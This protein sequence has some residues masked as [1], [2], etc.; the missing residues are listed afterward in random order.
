MT[1]DD[2]DALKEQ[3]KVKEYVQ[4]GSGRAGTRARASGAI[5]RLLA[6]ILRCKVAAVFDLKITGGTIVDGTRAGGNAITPR[7]GKTVV[8]AEPS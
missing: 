1:A 6:L 5:Y 2:T 7:R 4:V 8:R 3:V